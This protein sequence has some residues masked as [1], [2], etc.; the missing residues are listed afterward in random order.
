MLLIGS[1][2]GAMGC[3]LALFSVTVHP[4]CQCLLDREVDFVT[5]MIN[6]GRNRSAKTRAF[7]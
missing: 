7:C 1:V 5:A 6:I 3:A 4:L 2:I